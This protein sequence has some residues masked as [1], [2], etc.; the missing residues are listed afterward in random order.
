MLD[1]THA[2][3]EYDEE[4]PPP[5]L[6]Q[7]GYQT[8]NTPTIQTDACITDFLQQKGAQAAQIAMTEK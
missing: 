6:R 2:T 7:N 5:H 3:R 1:Q 4:R 8:Y